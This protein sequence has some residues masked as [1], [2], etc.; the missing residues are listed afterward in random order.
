MVQLY[1][2]CEGDLTCNK[3]QSEMVKMRC[4][5]SR[6]LGGAG[7][8]GVWSAGGDRVSQSGPSVPNSI[9]N[10]LNDVLWHGRETSKR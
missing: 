1:G 3:L 8:V 6:E 4:R 2:W 5:S 7:V 10:P 9:K